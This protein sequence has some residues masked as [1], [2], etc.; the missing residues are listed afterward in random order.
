MNLN[1]SRLL[2]Y[3]WNSKISRCELKDFKINPE[4]EKVK[5]ETDLKIQRLSNKSWK[6]APALAHTD[7]QVQDQAP[8]R[9]T[10]GRYRGCRSAKISSF[11][12]NFFLRENGVCLRIWRNEQ[13]YTIIP[14]QN[15][16]EVQKETT[17]KHL[18]N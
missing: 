13:K 7:V 10:W 15:V 17:I 12:F 18:I 6:V 11:A 2:N 1:I 9:F 3:I 5:R 16:G 14:H 8:P 4:I